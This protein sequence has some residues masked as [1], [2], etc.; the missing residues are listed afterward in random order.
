MPIDARKRAQ[1]AAADVALPVVPGLAGERDD[2]IE[3][4]DEIDRL[5][6]AHMRRGEAASDCATSTTS[7]R[8]LIVT[9]IRI[10][11]LVPARTVVARRER[12]GAS[13]W[14]SPRLA[15]DEVRLPCVPAGAGDQAVG[16]DRQSSVPP[17]DPVTARLRAGSPDDDT[18]R[19]DPG[20]DELQGRWHAR[21]S[22]NSR[23]PV[24]EDHR[25]D[26]EVELVDEVVAQQRL[27]QVVAAVD[28]ELGSVG[29]LE[30]CDGLGRV[31][32]EVHDGTRVEHRLLP[33]DAT[34]L[35][36]SLIG[37]APCASHVVGEYAPE[38]S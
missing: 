32:V 12:D 19:R 15:R 3:Q 31:A 21:R 4:N 17:I 26:P 23:L 33:R 10:G 25:E 2:R 8:S 35:V 5:S 38:L 7:E 14:P 11:V 36:A 1:P 18:R 28:L 27:D 37:L 6:R 13:T 24:A 34:F 29:L 30:R 20:V 22:A 16:R 9:T